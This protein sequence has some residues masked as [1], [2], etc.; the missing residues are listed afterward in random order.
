M[1]DIAVTAPPDPAPRP[2]TTR[3][4]KV[5]F[6]L[7]GVGQTLITLGFVVLLFIVYEVWITNIFAER[8][9][10]RVT[11]SLYQLWDRQNR[12][13][14]PGNGDPTVPIGQGMAVLYIPRLGRDYH[15]T[16]V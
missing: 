5:R 16:V 15:F 6:V 1:S 9:Q 11:K 3:G 8:E 12:L 10:K 14:L 7:R 4:D 2:A 13:G